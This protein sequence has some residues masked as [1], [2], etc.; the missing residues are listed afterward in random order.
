MSLIYGYSDKSDNANAKLTNSITNLSNGTVGQPK[1]NKEDIE[2]LTNGQVKTNKED[3]AK[4][5]AGTGSG[6]V[7]QVKTNKMDIANLAAGTVGQVKINK[8]DIASLAAGTVGQVKT[9]KVDIASLAAGA[10]GQV[11][12]NKTAILDLAAGTV[13]QVK[14][15][16]EN[17]AIASNFVGSAS[18][19]EGESNLKGTQLSHA[20]AISAH[21]NNLLELEDIV[22]YKDSS[23][24]KLVPVVKLTSG[25]L[26]TKTDS[27]TVDTAFGRIEKNKEDIANLVKIRETTGNFVAPLND[28]KVEITGWS[29]PARNTVIAV[30]LKANVGMT[31]LIKASVYSGVSLSNSDHLMTSP[32]HLNNMKLGRAAILFTGRSPK[33]DKMFANTRGNAVGTVVERTVKVKFIYLDHTDDSV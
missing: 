15:N 10:V 1:T 14:T 23:V 33:H 25:L 8:T 5:T 2:S 31:G 18:S 11:K 9:N 21:S 3:I 6:A 20:S 7:R 29:M 32:M 17:I 28:G 24:G 27:K 12:D 30:L 22:G 26:G 13:G 4:L 19:L 16:K